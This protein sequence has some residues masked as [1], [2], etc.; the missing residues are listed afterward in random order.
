ML[1]FDFDD[2][3]LD[4]IAAEYAATPKQVD[5]SRSRALKRTAATL[6]RL[7]STGLQTELGLRNAKAL[8]RRLKEYKVGKGNNALKLWFGA[9]DLPVSAFKGRPQK[10][11]GGIK[12]GDTMV[13]GAFFAKVGGKRKVM[14]RYGSKRWAIGEATLSVADRMMIYLED[15]VFV[16]ID[17]IY[18]EHFLAEIRART[19]L[20][21]G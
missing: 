6:R 1:A 8:R 20:G 2:G 9:N 19:I 15:E 10:V 12:F 18:M 13:H 14:K 3:Q 5:L 7:A 11:D 17:S 21:V 16:D 4:K